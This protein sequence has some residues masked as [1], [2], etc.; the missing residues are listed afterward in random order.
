L[1][2]Q[3]PAAADS[4]LTAAQ[5]A[6][7]HGRGERILIVEDDAALRASLIDL[8]EQ[9][10]YEVTAAANGEEA[11]ALLARAEAPVDAILSDVVMPRLG[12]IGLL[13]ALRAQGCTTPLVLMSGHAHGEERS[14][15]AEAGVVAWIDKP[16][17]TEELA[18]ALRHAVERP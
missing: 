15:L 10:C 6:Q 18:S 8:L 3:P 13:K 9:W 5:V 1:P 7:L 12:G 16:P 2:V 11:L 14:G 4:P 17:N